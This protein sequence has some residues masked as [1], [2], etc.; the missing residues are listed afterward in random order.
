LNALFGR[1]PQ[2]KAE[3]DELRRRVAELTARLETKAD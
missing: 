3:L 2:M 1:L